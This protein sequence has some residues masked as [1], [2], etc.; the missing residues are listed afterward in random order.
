MGNSA[1]A[2]TQLSPFTALTTDTGVSVKVLGSNFVPEATVRWNGADLPTTF[3]NSSELRAD[4]STSKLSTPGRVQLSVNNPGGGLSN[5]LPFDVYSS[6]P[7]PTLGSIPELGSIHA[8]DPGPKT[9]T[10]SGSQFV[11]NSVLRWNG[12]DRPTTTFDSTRL[13]AEIPASD[14]AVAGTYEVTVFNPGPGGGTSN[15]LTIQLN[16]PLPRLYGIWPDFAPVGGPD[17]TMAVFSAAGGTFNSASIVRWNG[18]DRPTTFVSRDILEAAIP[19]SDIASVG[20]AKVT[21]FNPAP[22]GGTSNEVTFDIVAHPPNDSFANA[23]EAQPIPFTYVVDDRGATTEPSDPAPSCDYDEDGNTSQK[24]TVWYKYTPSRNI[25]LFARADRANNTDFVIWEVLSVWVGTPGALVEHACGW[26]MWESVTTD[27]GFTASAGTTYYF[28]LSLMQHHNEQGPDLRFSLRE[29]DPVPTLD[30]LSPSS[31]LA[32]GPAFTL[33][34]NGSNFLPSS[35]VMWDGPPYGAYGLGG[36]YVSSTRLTVPISANLLAQAGTGKITVVNPYSVG[37]VS[38]ALP[39]VINPAPSVQ[40]ALTVIHSSNGTGT[41]TVTSNPAGIDCGATCSA[42]FA[43]GAVVDLTATPA[44]GST[45]VGWS[46]DCSGGVCIMEGP[47]KVT[48]TFD[49]APPPFNFG[50]PPAPRTVSAGQSAQFP[51]ELTGQAGFTGTVSFS[52]TSSVPQGVA[53]SFSPASVSPGSGTA[54]TTLTVTTTARTSAALITSSETAFAYLMAPLGLILVKRR[55][56]LRQGLLVVGFAVVL[57]LTGWIVAC[58]G[59]SGGG[60][61][62]GVNPNGTPPG[63]Y[64]ITVTGT[65]SNPSST[66]SVA[67]TLTV[68]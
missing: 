12:N 56:S 38:N 15:A 19:A 43:S 50:P 34:I 36:T 1:P 23:I 33:T 40:F 24:A 22:G 42:S 35:Y 46:G 7:V 10:A 17:F 60:Q 16:N 52:C 28:M 48:A 29:A 47:K 8:G 45:F 66:Q 58:G 39:F 62:P 3:V 53:C 18:S 54:T 32:G 6:H 57:A 2:I 49:T 37:G 14:Y 44:T 41:G 68:N 30:S 27:V 5:S 55:K 61:Q 9:L 11:T 64:T 21:V 31:A 26:S 63:T 25:D 4:V 13:T 51:L 59:G 65:S 67:V 20:T